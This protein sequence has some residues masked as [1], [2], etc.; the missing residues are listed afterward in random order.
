MHDHHGILLIQ[1]Y[2]LPSHIRPYYIVH[3]FCICTP[4]P[5]VLPCH[6]AIMQPLTLTLTRH[7]RLRFM[8]SRQSRESS[9]TTCIPPRITTSFMYLCTPH[10]VRAVCML[11]LTSW[12][13]AHL[14]RFIPSIL[15]PPTAL[16]LTMTWPRWYPCLA[17][18]DASASC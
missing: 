7:L 2:I 6:H 14:A 8:H 11:S 4:D 15:Q 9:I 3:C 10:P 17:V 13:P 16:L 18:S 1:H 5:S 12:A